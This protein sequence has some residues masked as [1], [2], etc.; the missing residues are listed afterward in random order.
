MANLGFADEL[1]FGFED[2]VNFGFEDEIILY[3]VGR[4]WLA[5]PHYLE[6]NYASFAVVNFEIKMVVVVDILQAA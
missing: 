2:E 1:N 3:V 4:Y 5:A 6:P